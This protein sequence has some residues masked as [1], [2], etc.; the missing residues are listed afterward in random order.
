MVDAEE[1]KALP[2]DQTRNKS[3]GGN[4]GGR[5]EKKTVGFRE[6]SNHGKKKNI[7][8]GKNSDRTGVDKTAKMIYTVKKATVEETKE[9]SKVA[10]T[11]SNA[12]VA[13]EEQKS[14]NTSREN[15]ATKQQ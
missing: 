3:D 8:H 9:Q 14:N 10:I 5:K 1:E 4:G 2:T 15:G 13:V 6:D 11:A 12:K 7:P